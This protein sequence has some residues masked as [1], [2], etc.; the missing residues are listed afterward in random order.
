MNGNGRTRWLVLVL[1]AAVA[2]LAVA[3][4]ILAVGLV[5]F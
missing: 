5:R 2:V 1:G 4:V 3:L